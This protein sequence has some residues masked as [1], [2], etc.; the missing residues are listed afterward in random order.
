[1][2]KIAGRSLAWLWIAFFAIVGSTLVSPGP[3]VAQQADAQSL[4]ERT[5]R[6]ENGLIPASVIKG[7]P[8]PAFSIADRMRHF[9]V[10]GLSA[11]FIDHGRVVWARAYGYADIASGRLVTTNTIFQ[12]AS[13]SKPLTAMAAMRLVQRGQ[14][15]LDNDV[16]SAL[17]TWKIPQNEF[18]RTQKVTLRELL[19][20]T[21]GMTVHGFSGYTPGQ[22]LPTLAEILDGRPPANSD[23]IRVD[24]TPGT[25]YSY[26]GGGYV[27]IR[28][29]LS[30]VTGLPFPALMQQLVLEPLG[31]SHSTF[32]QPLPQ[33]L[34]SSA[35]TAYQSDGQ[36]FDGRFNT[37]P[38]LGP[39]GLW[40]T[41]SDLAKFAIAVQNA[42]AGRP[43]TILLQSTAQTMLKQQMA[44][45][46]LG[47]KVGSDDGRDYFDHD[48]SNFGFFS[49]M[50]AFS[51]AGSQG[52]VVM[53]N[54]NNINLKTEFIRAVAREYHWPG[55]DPQEHVLASNVSG[56]DL[57]S[58]AGAYDAPDV[59]RIVVSDTS[60]RLFLDAPG[61]RIESEEMFPESATRFFIQ[62]STSAFIFNK[63]ASGNVT[64]LTIQQRNGSIEAK[65]QTPAR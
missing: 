5:S 1:M 57:A 43:N 32:E 55:F 31:M 28:T 58:C 27:V 46:A 42:L 15:Q 54:G 30:D 10:P 22:P 62:T 41:P 38:E 37:Y 26:S 13:I 24:A 11:A 52:V 6:I 12:A 19:S 29:L 44:G 64:S 59:G 21:A 53:T 14:L 51:G 63:D 4:A 9:R 40:S 2:D 36:P 34:Q 7:Q 16:N 50:F 39:D 49:E 17:R 47:F 33:A 3:V 60:N 20:H 25:A 8:V 23:P 65:K 48:G 35:A 61:M 45:Y 18:T 56:E